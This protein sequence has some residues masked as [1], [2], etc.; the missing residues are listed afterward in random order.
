MSSAEGWRS[1]NSRSLAVRV[2]VEGWNEALQLGPEP[3][4][5]IGLAPFLDFCVDAPK[6]PVNVVPRYIVVFNAEFVG[7]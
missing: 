3:L 6:G 5:E 4:S 7:G 2:W 1:T